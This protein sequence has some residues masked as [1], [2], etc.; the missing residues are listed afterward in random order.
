[1]QIV[2]EN[3]QTNEQTKKTQNINS[4]TSHLVSKAKQRLRVSF[5][6]KRHE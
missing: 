3:K 1:M 5:L 4:T 6:L 2:G